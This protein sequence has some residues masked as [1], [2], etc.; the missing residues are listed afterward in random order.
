MPSPAFRDCLSAARHPS[1]VPKAIS[2]AGVLRAAQSFAVL[3]KKK[4]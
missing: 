1:R 4:M 2:V 3:S